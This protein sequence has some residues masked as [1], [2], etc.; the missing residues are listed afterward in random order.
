MFEVKYNPI[1][2]WF[3]DGISGFQFND[4]FSG[5][6]SQYNREWDSDGFVWSEYN[7]GKVNV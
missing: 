3:Y 2:D 1:S 4:F 6:G 7:K 5:V